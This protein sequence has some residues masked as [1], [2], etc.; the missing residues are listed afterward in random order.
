MVFVRGSSGLGKTAL[1]RRFLSGLRDRQ[2]DAVLLTG[3]CYERESVPYKA[4]DSLADRLSHYLR[5]LPSAEVEALL[6]RDVTALTRLFPI[7]QRVDAIAANRF[8]PA[9]VANAQE[10]RRRSFAAFRELLARL[11]DRHPV[12]LVVDDLQWGDSD[13]AALIADLMF[14]AEAPALLF[15]A[16]YRFEERFSS[17]ALRALLLGDDLPS[18][19]C[20]VNQIEVGELSEPE[21]YELAEALTKTHGGTATAI[22]S[23]VRESHGSPFF[24]NELIQYSAATM[25]ADHVSVSELAVNHDPSSRVDLDTVIRTRTGR[26][27]EG[28]RRLLRAM[29]IFGGPLKLSVAI[30]AAGLPHGG[31]EDVTLLRAA[32]LTRTRVVGAGE[33]I[34]FYHDRIRE[35][36]LAEIPKDEI[37]QL[38]TRLAT[39][40][41]RSGDVSPETLLFHFRGAG[42]C[43]VASGYALVAADRARDAVAFDRAASYYR[44]ALELGDLAKAKR[45]EI[46]IK[47]GD[48]LAASGRGYD[49]AQAY[50]DAAEGALAADLIDLRRRAADQLLRSGHIDEGLDAIRGVLAALQMSLAD[51]PLRALVSLFL[52]RLWIRIRGLEFQARDRSQISGDELVRVDA[53]WT[54]ATAIGV[55]DTICGADFQARHLILA[56]DTGDPFRVARALALDSAYVA[57]RGSRTVT[58]QRK[59]ID[60]ARRLADRVGQPEMLPLVLL[61]DGTGAFFQG[62]W[63]QAHEC[64]DRVEPMLRECATSIA[65]E[66]DTAHLYDLLAL[67]YLGEVSELPRRLPG[68]LKEA[69][70]RDDLTAATNLRTRVAYLIHLAA[71]NP[72]Q[73]R[74]EVRQGMES[75]ARGAFHAQHSW[76]MYAYGEIDLYCAQGSDAWRWVNQNWH[77]LKRS[78]LLRIQAVRIEFH[79]LHGRSALA[80]AVDPTWSDSARRALVKNAARTAKQL[81]REGAAWAA[82]LA[83]LIDAGVSS[84]HGRAARA[85]LQLERAEAAFE[86]AEMALHAAVARRRRGELVGGAE[87]ERLTMDADGWMNGQAIAKPARIVE[88]LAPGRF[89]RS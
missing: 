4:L 83:G 56:L 41:Q 2:L 17:A 14:G 84:F 76:E 19:G 16:C 74:Q 42:Q 87:G 15:V 23:V 50:F 29:A 75:W 34:E 36:I 70:E 55:V 5:T 28:P 77:F 7:L 43:D 85:I 46:Q 67:F 21:A 37:P 69:R 45:C 22:E 30:E 3:R 32:H 59:L 66:L 8:R 18:A 48:A 68:F 54:V 12:V 58:R 24:I 25:L 73:A 53:C 78:L 71:D 60:M 33:E 51:S 44:L 10:L 52:R 39:V 82:A 11:S 38:H 40:L 1:I 86:H 6:P 57:L 89:G 61:A 31:L 47:L 20:D 80:A 65:W 13:S 49:A 63:R 72:E 88:M 81:R 9:P 35:A 64:F 26:L 79:Y 27:G 62:Q